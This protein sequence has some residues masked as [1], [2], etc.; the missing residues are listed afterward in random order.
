MNDT[1]LELLKT[2]CK[3]ILDG[4]SDITL[5]QDEYRLLEEAL[6]NPISMSFRPLFLKKVGFLP[7]KGFDY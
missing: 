4:N 7:V 5:E 3:Q 6:H 1:D 2:C